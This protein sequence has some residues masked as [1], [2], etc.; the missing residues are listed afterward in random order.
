MKKYKV[1]WLHFMGHFLIIN[2]IMYQKHTKE[3]SSYFL[4]C[5]DLCEVCSVD[6]EDQT[7]AIMKINLGDG[8]KSG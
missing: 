7:E 1:K 8:V 6:K 4:V 2:K 3:T 5:V